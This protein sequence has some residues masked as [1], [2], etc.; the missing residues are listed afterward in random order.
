MLTK[1][2]LHYIMKKNNNAILIQER[3]I[4]I[5]KVQQVRVGR[6]KWQLLQVASASTRMMQGKH[7]LGTGEDR[8]QQTLP[9]TLFFFSF[10][11]LRGDVTIYSY[12]CRLQLLIYY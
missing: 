1:L 5:R 3:N 9:S 10:F 2:Q 11:F 12:S 6:W 4:Q 7:M 8:K